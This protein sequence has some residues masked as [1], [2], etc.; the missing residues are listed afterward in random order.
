W[1]SLDTCW[2]EWRSLAY[3]RGFRQMREC[4][5]KRTSQSRQAVLRFRPPESSQAHGKTPCWIGKQVRNGAAKFP[6][7]IGENDFFTVHEVQAFGANPR[8]NNGLGHR[9]RFEN[10]QPRA[11][12]DA[13]R[14]DANSGFRNLGAQVR[15]RPGEPHPGNIGKSSAKFFRSAS[16]S[17]DKVDLGR[18]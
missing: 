5:A 4:F 9:G 8:R 10:L 18:Q 14:N 17:D 2:S 1:L 6:G 3:V 15:N 7:F 16:P 12:A 11:A 13:Q